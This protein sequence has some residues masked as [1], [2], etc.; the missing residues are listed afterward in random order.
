MTTIAYNNGVLAADGLVSGPPGV[1]WTMK[2]FRR[3]GAVYGGCG[4]RS[5]IQTLADWYFGDRKEQPKYFPVGDD[6][7]SASILVMHDDGRVYQCGFDA[8]PIEVPDYAAI[9]SGSEY[10][11][12]AMYMGASALRAVEA[13]ICHDSDSGGGIVYADRGGDIVNY[14]N[15]I[16]P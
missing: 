2:L 4:V 11:V 12:G 13:A 16:Y 9:G 3:D 14:P 10:A 7:P 6:G 15:K 8:C 1:R 5:Q